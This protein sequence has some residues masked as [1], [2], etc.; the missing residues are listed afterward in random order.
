MK[1]LVVGTDGAEDIELVTIC[2][3]LRRGG[4]QVTLGGLEHEL[5]NCA[6]G[7]VLKADVAPLPS[8]PVDTFNA[9]VLPGGSKAAQTFATNSH[10]QTL[11]KA[12]HGKGKLVAAICAAPMALAAAGILN[13]KRATIYPGMEKHLSDGDALPV[14]DERVVVDGNIVTS[15]APGTAMAFALKLV[16]ILAGEGTSAKVG[17]A[18]LYTG[19]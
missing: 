3:V 8:S 10:C 9:L 17:H 12:M 4:L 11:I 5:I 14:K 2:D 7:C 19:Q 18:M 13:G 15:Q 1:V 6:N 16:E